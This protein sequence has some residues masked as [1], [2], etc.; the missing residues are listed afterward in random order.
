M[1]AGDLTTEAFEAAQLAAERLGLPDRAVTVLDR[2]NNVVVR[3]GEVVLKVGTAAV[4][5]RREVELA[6]HASAR[7]GPV[8]T[9]LAPPMDC[10]PFTISAWPYL[11]A[12]DAP[13]VEAVAARALAALHR[14]LVDTSVRLPALGDR[15]G[16]V[17]LL[18]DD[19]TATAAL[20]PADR[21]LLAR[22]VDVVAVDVAGAVPVV[23]HA[24]PHDGNRLTVGGTVMY[25]DLEASCRGPLE[26]DLAYFSERV[27]AKVWPGHDRQLR[28]R[29]AL[30]VRACVST[31]CWRHVTSRPTDT[32]M[33]W[34]AEHHLEGVRVALKHV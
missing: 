32:E 34:H 18:L 31:Y 30:G 27:A 1:P 5:M 15:L 29:L 4:R 17:R 3:I 24:Q 20:A 28:R 12:D 16:E 8:P 14:S 11:L 21:A 6:L 13:A 33:R 19:D 26:W 2:S 25:L 10:G 23:L 22:A 7:G 9:P